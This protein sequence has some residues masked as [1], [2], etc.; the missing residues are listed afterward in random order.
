V[1][2]SCVVSTGITSGNPVTFMYPPPGDVVPCRGIVLRMDIDEV[3]SDEAKLVVAVLRRRNSVE[4][5]GGVMMVVAE[6]CPSSFLLFC[7][8]RLLKILRF[9]FVVVVSCAV[10]LFDSSDDVE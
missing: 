5:R 3:G 10:A 4:V 2:T 1:L 9:V 7:C 8:W 6:N